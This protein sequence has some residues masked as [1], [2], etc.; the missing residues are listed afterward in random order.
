MSNAAAIGLGIMGWIL[1]AIL[2]ALFVGRMIELRDR[3]RPDPPEPGR[4]EPPAPG[5]LPP[6]TQ[7]DTASPPAS[8]GS[9]GRK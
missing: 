3:Q 5:E 6:D 4:S 1:V 7:A 8:S 9:E 2:L